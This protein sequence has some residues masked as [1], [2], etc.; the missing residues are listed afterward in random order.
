MVQD[1]SFDHDPC[2]GSYGE[3]DTCSAVAGA[4]VVVHLDKTAENARF[5]HI[6]YTICPTRVYQ[7]L[8][9]EEGDSGFGS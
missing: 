4:I 2:S 3:V 1:V 5:D 6:P 7:T 9:E 8:Y